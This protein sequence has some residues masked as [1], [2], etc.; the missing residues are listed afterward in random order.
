MRTTIQFWLYLCL[1]SSKSIFADTTL[2]LRTEAE[3]WGTQLNANDYSLTNSIGI[4][5]YFDNYFVGFNGTL[6]DV[7][8]NKKNSVKFYHHDFDIS[9]GTYLDHHFAV[10]T[11]LR[12]INFVVEYDNEDSVSFE[13]DTYGPVIGG[14]AY[15]KLLNG[16]IF[17]SSINASW[18]RSTSN[19][20]NTNSDVN[21]KG[22]SYAAE[23]GF[24]YQISH[25]FDFNI[26]SKYQRINLQYENGEWQPDFLKSGFSIIYHF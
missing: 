14:L 21:A 12:Y 6:L 11:G 23:L 1:F 24:L 20:E 10:F 9:V 4:G 25:S 15:I 17:Y 7:T 13:E 3:R 2:Q 26:F 16:L 22:Y 5:H 18:L 8:V 19:L